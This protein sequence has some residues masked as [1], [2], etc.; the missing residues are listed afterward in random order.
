MKR[1]RGVEGNESLADDPIELYLRCPRLTI[2]GEGVQS[3]PT[4]KCLRFVDLTACPK[5]KFIPPLAFSSCSFHREVVWNSD[6]IEEIGDAAFQDCHALEKV[7]IP[8][9]VKKLG[10]G[11]FRLCHSL[12]SVVLNPKC[13]SIGFQCFTVCSSL[14]D[15]EFHDNISDI[16]SGAFAQTGLTSVKL[17]AK[18]RV[19]ENEVFANCKNLAEVILNEKL[20]SIGDSAFGSCKSLKKITFNKNL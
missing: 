15:F 20:R 3:F 10:L 2:L 16:A 8:L 4:C 7:T 18:L 11:T 17:P 14:V 12:E 9:R 1:L 6:D 5:L 19:L 13:K